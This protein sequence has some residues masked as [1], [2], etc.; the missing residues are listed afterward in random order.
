VTSS[1]SARR[2]DREYYEELH[3][4]SVKYQQNNWLLADF[5]RLVAL[6]GKSIIEI[7]CGN[8]L[9]LERAS[10]HW[11]LVVGVDWV[12]AER[13]GRVLAELPAVRFLQQD[14]TQLDIKELFDLLVSADVLE[15]L[16]PSALPR[17]IARLH[18]LGR[19]CYHKIACYDD[20]HSHL[21]VFTAPQWLTLF[22]EAVPDGGYRIVGRQFRGRRR[23]KRVIVIS[24][25][26]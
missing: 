4:T 15:H 16:H 25:G 6:G 7:G 21:S 1:A 14:L 23:K 24:N 8:G 22:E 19:L 17:V 18:A 10:R 26:G 5:P 3:R 20:G 2:S 11:P 13:L 9:F 12:R